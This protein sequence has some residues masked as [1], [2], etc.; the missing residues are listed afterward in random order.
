MQPSQISSVT[1]RIIQEI[2][3]LLERQRVQKRM[4]HRFVMM[5]GDCPNK[6]IVRISEVSGGV[7]AEPTSNIMD[8]S[9][10]EVK[11]KDIEANQYTLKGSIQYSGVD[12]VA[13]RIGP[14]WELHLS[15]L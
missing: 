11:I 12:V 5:G 10:Q 9:Y 7:V 8:K 4:S 1:T 2:F 14:G 15:G 13:Q 6:Y 3:L